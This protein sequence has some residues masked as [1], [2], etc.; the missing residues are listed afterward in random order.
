MRKT[1]R[2]MLCGMAFVVVGG[3]LCAPQARADEVAYLVNVTVRPGYHFAN[4]DDA[5]GYG[6]GI[7]DKIAQ[8]R[9][10]GQLIDD[11]KTDF[12]TTDDFQASYLITQAANELC[13]STIW[14]LR[15]SAAS[16]Q[17]PAS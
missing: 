2:E 6:R 15:R 16:Y 10:Y 7:C 17:V 14:Q 1:S 9:P 12:A 8:D 4:A 5:L 3:V 13:P 11:V